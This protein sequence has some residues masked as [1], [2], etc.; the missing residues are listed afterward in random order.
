[1]N[2]CV[3]MTVLAPD[4]TGIVQTLSQTVAD[5]SGNWL[6]SRMARMAGHF[7]GILRVECPE[8]NAAALIAALE[9]LEGMSIQTRQEDSDPDETRHLLKLDVVGNDRPGIVRALSGAIAATGA[10]LEELQTTLESA[11]MAGHPIFH[12]KGIA[13]LPEGL[14][15]GALTEAIEDLGPDLA[16]TVEE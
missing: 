13:S 10:N 7:A 15:P 6:E 5:H 2:T 4:R 3:V 1:M 14:A 8:A 12:A 16:V 9:A 11:P